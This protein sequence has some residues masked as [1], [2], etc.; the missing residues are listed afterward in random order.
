MTLEKLKHILWNNKRQKLLKLADNPHNGSIFEEMLKKLD[1]EIESKSLKF[2]LNNINKISHL[3]MFWKSDLESEV[4]GEQQST[5]VMDK[6]NLSGL[7]GLDEMR[8]A[9]TGES[10]AR[11][12]F[13]GL[14]NDA[15]EEDP[16]YNFDE[17]KNKYNS[18]DQD[19]KNKF[20]ENLKQLADNSDDEPVKDL[21]MS[22]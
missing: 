4:E 10:L 9:D 21:G 12:T 6:R 11:E 20:E 3:Y 1:L 16:Y 17:I 18:L 7:L 19:W 2:D 13:E 22:Y 14:E 5:W 8:W 15:Y